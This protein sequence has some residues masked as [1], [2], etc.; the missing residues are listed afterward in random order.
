MDLYGLL[1]EEAP[2]E[3]GQGIHDAIMECDDIELLRRLALGDSAD[4]HWRMSA[5]QR[6]ISIKPTSEVK[7]ALIATLRQLKEK[8][9]GPIQSLARSRLGQIDRT[10]PNAGP[11]AWGK[12]VFNPM[13]GR[14]LHKH[15]RELDLTNDHDLDLV[16]YAA[17]RQD[18]YSSSVDRRIAKSLYELLPQERRDKVDGKLREYLGWDSSTEKYFL[19]KRLVEADD[20]ADLLEDAVLAVGGWPGSFAFARLTG[21]STYEEE[22]Y[23]SFLTFACRRLEGYP[24]GRQKALLKQLVERDMLDEEVATRLLAD[25]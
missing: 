15:R 5:M 16:E 21:W 23:W 1:R 24:K 7:A 10:D 13:L 22:D 4:T 2:V 20:D 9:A 12:T 17:R 6:L 11:E 14:Y 8:G 19:L 3:E 25:A 18:D